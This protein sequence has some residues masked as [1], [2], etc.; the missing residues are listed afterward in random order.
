MLFLVVFSIEIDD[1][2][3]LRAETFRVLRVYI[4]GAGDEHILI[5]GE[6]SP[7]AVGS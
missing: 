2:V 6:G 5:D 7:I 1:E 3:H 4:M